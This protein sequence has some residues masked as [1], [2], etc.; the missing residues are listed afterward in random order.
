MNWYKIASDKM[1]IIVRGPSGSGK[2]NLAKRLGANGQ[3][4]SSDD[5]FMVNGKYQFNIKKLHQA[6]KWNQGRVEQA[7][8]NNVPLIVL[9]NTNTMAWEISPYVKS[10]LKYGY[11]IEMREPD[12]HE[13]LFTEEGKWNT[14]FLEG[15]NTHGVN[16]DI[17]SKMVNRYEYNLS[18]NDILE[19]KAPWEK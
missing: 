14:D 2:S 8:Q 12:W 6:H 16:R 13:D 5:F 17:L 10:A 3:I 19:S 15:R 11:E 7:M 1:F 18:V 4:F 9:D